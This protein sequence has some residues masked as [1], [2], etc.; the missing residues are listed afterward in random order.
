MVIIAMLFP[1]YNSEE[2]YNST[3]ISITAVLEYLVFGSNASN[4]F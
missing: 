3:I 4:I 1:N 2:S